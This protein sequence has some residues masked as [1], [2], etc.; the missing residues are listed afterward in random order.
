MRL[1]PRLIRRP[2]G[3]ALDCVAQYAACGLDP[4]KSHQFAQSHAIGHTELAWVLTCLTPI[5]E[6]QRMTQFKDKVP[7]LGSKP[8]KPKMA[9][10]SSPMMEQDPK[11]PSTQDCSAT[12]SSWRPTSSFTMQTSCPLGRTNGNTWSFAGISLNVSTI[13][14]PILSPFPTPMSLRPE[15]KSSPLPNRQKCRNQTKTKGPRFTPST[16]LIRSR[17]RRIRR[18]R[19]GSGHPFFTR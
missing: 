4:E 13:S 10:S 2:C 6:L 5:G 17:R 12:L 19:F 11:H 8:R 7:S 1:R 14:F 16:N 9:R 3:N 15:R 18:D